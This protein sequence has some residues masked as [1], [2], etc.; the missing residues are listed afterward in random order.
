M[1]KETSTITFKFKPVL[2]IDTTPHM[3]KLVKWYKNFAVQYAEIEDAKL[4]SI[5]AD[6]NKIMIT[7]SNTD[8]LSQSDINSLIEL[9]VNPDEDGNHPIKIRT[10]TYLISGDNIEIKQNGEWIQM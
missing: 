3:E 1:T 10:K 6:G 5:T 4:D 7:L 9:I 8:T 2:S